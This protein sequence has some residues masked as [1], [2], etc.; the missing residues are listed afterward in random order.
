MPRKSFKIIKFRYTQKIE[1]IH[2]DICD[3]NRGVTQ[4][5]SK[6]FITFIDDYF[7]FCYTYFLKTR[8]EM[9]NKFKISKS[10]VENQQE[11]RIKILRSDQDGEY[12]SN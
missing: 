6:Y 12:T 1:L 11:K 10:E 7:R 4:G 5:G 3:S 8:D 9:L 2:S